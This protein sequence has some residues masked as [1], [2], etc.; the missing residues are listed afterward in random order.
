MLVCPCTGFELTCKKYSNYFYAS[1]FSLKN[2]SERLYAN[3]EAYLR[4]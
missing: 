2:L 3:S 1:N 4:N